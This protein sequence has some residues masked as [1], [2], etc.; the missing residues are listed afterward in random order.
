[1]TKIVETLEQATRRADYWKAEYMK[2]TQMPLASD[3]IRAKIYG[4]KID[5]LRNALKRIYYFQQDM[6]HPPIK[7]VAE[8]MRDIAKDALKND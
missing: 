7:S 1:M 6:E 2:T 5:A 3:A 8:M 4:D